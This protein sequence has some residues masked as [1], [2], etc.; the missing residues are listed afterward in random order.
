M[1]SV[2]VAS[3]TTGVALASLDQ[4]LGWLNT[5][6]SIVLSVSSA[7][8]IGLVLFRYQFMET[9][10]KKREDLRALLETEL[11]EFRR[12]LLGS[13]TFVPN[14]AL[15]DLRPSASHEIPLSINHPHPL[16]I[17]EAARS[18]LFG[19]EPTAGMLV[20]VRDMGAH[21]HDLREATSLEPH[22][23]R[24]WAHGLHR[25]AEPA[26]KEFLRLHR[27]YAQAAKMVQLSEE[28][29]IAGCEEVLEGLH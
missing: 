27:R 18:G 7:L 17:E 4:L 6:L 29:I 5:L 26:Q 21:D 25:Q 24:P 8:V 1:I 22:I 12:D 9:D 16:V 28:S 11:E 3:Y 14:E 20:L 2:A 23:D 13:R 19:V 10:R 15:E